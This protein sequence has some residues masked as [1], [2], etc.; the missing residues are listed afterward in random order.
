MKTGTPRD[1]LTLLGFATV[2]WLGTRT[3]TGFL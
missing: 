1:A 2:V 3:D